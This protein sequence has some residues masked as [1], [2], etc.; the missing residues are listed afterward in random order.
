MILLKLRC[1]YI[2]AEIKNND[3]IGMTEL[4]M[5]IV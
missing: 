3:K 2:K 1:V 5:K 4:Q